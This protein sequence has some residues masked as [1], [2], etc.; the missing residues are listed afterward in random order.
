MLPFWLIFAVPAFAAFSETTRSSAVRR[1]TFAFLA[2]WLFLTILIGLRYQ[3]GGDWRPYENMFLHISSLPFSEVFLS[4]DPGY[5][6]L[7]WLVARAGFNVFMVNT[8]CAAVFSTGLITFARRQPLPWLALAIAAPYLVTVVAMGYTR[9]SVAIGFAMLA[10][11][12]LSANSTIRFAIWITMA[13]LFHKTAVLLI[14]VALLA[15]TRSRAWTFL[16]IGSFGIVLY[17]LLL[18]DSVDQLIENYLGSEYQ[19]QGATIRVAMNALPAALFL[20]FWRHFK[21]EKTELILWTYLS[22]GALIFVILLFVSP[23]ST[24]VDRMALYFI[25]VQI[26]VLSRLPLAWHARFGAGQVTRIGVI[27]YSA[28]VLFVWLNYASHA[29]HWLPYQT[30]FS[31]G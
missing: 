25:P 26:F 24:A 23:S 8:L 5:T 9:Q 3:V 28:L 29:K 27:I 7:N 21:L 14:P 12:G 18:A 13:A 10:L 6:L 19:S 1:K 17:S 20:L 22:I 15:K 31:S 2:I 30:I 16:W 11:A 4:G